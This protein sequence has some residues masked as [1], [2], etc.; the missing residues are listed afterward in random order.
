MSAEGAIV[1]HALGKPGEVLRVASPELASA[2]RDGH[3]GLDVVCA[4][5]PEIDAMLA[6]FREKM[7]EDRE[8]AERPRKPERSSSVHER[9]D[10]LGAP[11]VELGWVGDREQ[12]AR[13][14]FDHKAAVGRLARPA[15]EG[16]LKHAGS[17]GGLHLE[18]A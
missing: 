17:L 12:I 14:I 2:L 15:I 6:G 5:T 8:T 11:R 18:A 4:P 16:R 1:G 10:Q 13:D 7:S 9:P 3:P